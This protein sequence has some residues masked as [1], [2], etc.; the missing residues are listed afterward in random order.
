MTKNRAPLVVRTTLCLLLAASSAL[1]Q[2]QAAPRLSLRGRG[3]TL[4]LQ[5]G[6]R[7]HALKL[8]GDK[9]DAAR[10]EHAEIVFATRRPDFTYLLVDVCGW[11]K[12]RQ[13]ERHCGLGTECN[14][15]WLK[16]TTAW[17]V[18]DARSARYLSCWYPTSNKEFQIKG[19]TLSVEYS[20]YHA[21][22]KTLLTYDADQP[23]RGFTL[24]ASPL[25]QN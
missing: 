3:R 18:A 5:V 14:L 16:L 4:V 2:R 11:S 22:Q 20:D 13:D 23:E 24:A 7:A 17:R 9:I 10:L 8:A 25:A 15:L 6:G 12:P 19:R 21:E 1:A